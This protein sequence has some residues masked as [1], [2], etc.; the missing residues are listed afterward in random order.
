MVLLSTVVNGE[1]AIHILQRTGQ[2]EL[3]L[4]TADVVHV[5]HAHRYGHLFIADAESISYM[6][7]VHSV[8]QSL[9]LDDAVTGRAVADDAQLP[10]RRASLCRGK[11]HVNIS[12]CARGNCLGQLRCGGKDIHIRELNIAYHQIRISHIGHCHISCICAADRHSAEVYLVCVEL[13]LGTTDGHS[14]ALTAAANG[15]AV[16]VCQ[17]SPCGLQ[18]HTYRLAAQL[19]AERSHV[20][21]ARGYRCHRE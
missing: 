12:R 18:C 1:A 2:H 6:K 5:V 3:H 17:H 8:G 14:A 4:V 11:R 16:P 10:L 9:Q 7:F 20:T 13:C 19:E 15:V 21:A